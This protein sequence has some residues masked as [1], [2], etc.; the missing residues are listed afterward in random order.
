MN[1]VYSIIWNAA[2]GIWVVVSEL[3]KG[4][5]KSSSRKTVAVLAAGALLSTSPLVMADETGDHDISVDYNNIVIQPGTNDDIHNDGFL[6]KN[7]TNGAVLNVTGALP[8]IEQGQTGLV[9]SATIEQLLEQKK[10]TLTA[11][12]GGVSTPITEVEDLKKYYFNQPSTTPSQDKEIP[13]IDPA[14]ET[15]AAMQ[16]YNTDELVRYLTETPLD[17][18]TLNTYDSTLSKIYNDFGIAQASDGSTANLNIGNDQK[19]AR[20]AENTIKLL[21]KIAPCL[22]PAVQAARLTGFPITTSLLAPPPSSRTKHL[23]VLRQ[24]TSSAKY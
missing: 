4:K 6:Y 11:N 24:W 3:T 1:K 20:D 12:I 17:G 5:K 13:I 2:L 8:K 22:K 14:L 7:A 18:I 21:A 16:V 9:E 10:I 19:N 23:T 15:P